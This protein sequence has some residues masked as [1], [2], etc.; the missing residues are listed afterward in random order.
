MAPEVE[1]ES[2]EKD[3]KVKKIL[4]KINT[5]ETDSDLVKLFWQKLSELNREK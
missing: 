1:A 2:S 3:F 4:H 5:F